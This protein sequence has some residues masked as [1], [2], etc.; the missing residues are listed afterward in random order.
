MYKHIILSK[1][2]EYLKLKQIPTKKSGVMVSFECPFCKKPSA[3]ILPN[4]HKVNCFSCNPKDKIGR[5]YNLVDIAIAIDKLDGSEEEVLEYLKDI[6]NVKVYTKRDE[7]T[8][9][10]MLQHYQKLGF[11]LVPI[12]AGG[13]IPVE[14][15]WTEKSHKDID[16]WRRWIRDGLNI[17]VKTGRLSN[18]LV[19]DVDCLSKKEKSEIRDKKASKSRETELEGKRKANLKIVYDELQKVMGTPLIQESLG[20]E[21]FFYKHDAEIPKTN[22]KIKDIPIDV[23]AEGG[24]ILIYPSQV[25]EDNFRR[26]TNI[27]EISEIPQLPKEFKTYLES[28]VDKVPTPSYDEKIIKDIETED[29]KINPKDFQLKNNNL[30]G[31]CNSSFIKLGGILRKNLNAKETAFVLHTLNRHMLEDPMESKAI[32]NMVRELDKYI[33]FDGEDLANKVLEYLK[34]VEEANRTEIAMAVVNTNRGED[35]KRVD[36]ALQY[37]AKE[38]LLIKHGR[39]YSIFKKP[40]W[41]E[42]LINIGVPIDFEMPFF[43]DIMDFNKG[44]LILIGS[45][46]ATGKT[47]IAMNIIKALVKQK[48]KPYYL[49]LEGGSRW[50]KIALQLGLKEGD[51][52]WEETSNPNELDLEPESITIIDWLCPNNYAETDKLIKSLNDKVRDTKGILIVFVQLRDTNEWLAKD[53][54]KQFPAL[55]CRYMYDNQE[56]GEYGKFV[57]DKIREPKIKIKSYE[58]PCIYDWLTKELNRVDVVQANKPKEKTETKQEDKKDEKV[59]KSSGSKE[60]SKGKQKKKQ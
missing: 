53:L 29:F 9:D 42:N 41:K 13:K 8:I 6:L 28:K 4:T 26:F 59:S 24:Y 39:S 58:I 27:N 47:H 33:T 40:E 19:I 11:D 31:V 52:F 44:D 15:K 5:Y 34:S 20:G 36:L 22:I 35:K 45:R 14:S 10:T 25:K 2:R 17:G 55:A 7:D 30:E 12:T 54:I 51:F 18:I 60:D 48:I 46:N 1:L 23:E 16:E 43:Y 38:G 49:S 56:S 21:H 3:N 37:L 57:L 32:T 50:A